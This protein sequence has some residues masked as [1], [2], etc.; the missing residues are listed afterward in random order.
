MN[1]VTETISSLRQRFLDEM[2]LRKFA[3]KT[4]SGYIRAVSRF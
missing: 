3:P 2:R 4:Q 1:S